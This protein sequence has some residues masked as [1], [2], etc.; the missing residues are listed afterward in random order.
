[1][2]QQIRQVVGQLISTLEEPLVAL[3]DLLEV[4]STWKGK[5]NSLAVL[6]ANE[7]QQWL[8]ANPDARQSGLRLR[9]LQGRALS[10]VSEGQL[11]DLLSDMYRIAEAD[12]AF[13]LGQVTHLHRS[14]KYKEVI[15]SSLLM[16]K[17]PSLQ[18]K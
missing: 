17:S 18:Y 13:L 16:A 7:F 12:R 5:G 6:I 2:V 14:G 10:L 4:T 1:M 8:K 15:G 9:K 11:L 3:L